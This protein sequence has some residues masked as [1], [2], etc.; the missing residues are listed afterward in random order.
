MSHRTRVPRVVLYRV[1]DPRWRIHLNRYFEG[2]PEQVTI[3]VAFVLWRW[4]L[5]V[6]WARLSDHVGGD[7]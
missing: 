6:V 2:T 1:A 5:S 3:G 7:R 4:C